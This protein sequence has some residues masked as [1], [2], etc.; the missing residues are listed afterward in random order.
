MEYTKALERRKRLREEHHSLI[1]EELA[2]MEKELGTE[3]VRKANISVRQTLFKL[4][5]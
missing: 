1:Q 4:M 2:K 5:G 3:K